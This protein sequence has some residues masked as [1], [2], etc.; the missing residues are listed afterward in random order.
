VHTASIIRVMEAVHTSPLKC[1]SSS[2]RLHCAYFRRLSSSYSLPWASQIWWCYFILR[3]W[4]MSISKVTAC[5]LDRQGLIPS[6][7]R[8]APASLLFMG[9][10]DF[11]PRVKKLI[12][13]LHLVPRL[14]TCGT[15][16]H[17]PCTPYCVEHRHRGN[18]HYFYITGMCL[19]MIPLRSNLLP[20]A[21]GP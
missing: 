17:S 2:R 11:L 13:H 10:V 8:D 9:T 14:R 7:R 18:L 15:F 6:R 16:D 12:T 20:P 1:H 4:V 19:Y 21:W 5:G 3:L